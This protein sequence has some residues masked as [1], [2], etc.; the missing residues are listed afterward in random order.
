MEDV[1]SRMHEVCEESQERLLR[2]RVLMGLLFATLPGAVW[3]R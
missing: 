3:V 2:V 1:G